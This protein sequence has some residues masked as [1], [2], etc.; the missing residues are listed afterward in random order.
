MTTQECVPAWANAPSSP[1][2]S[3]MQFH[4]GVKVAAAKGESS[5]VRE[6]GGSY[7]EQ[8][9]SGV[10]AAFNGAYR[11]STPEAVWDPDTGW[12]TT[13]HDQTYAKCQH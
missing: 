6:K 1:A 9:L 7:P 10:V 4:T 5:V 8:H 3:L 2:C 13:A 12:V 11:G